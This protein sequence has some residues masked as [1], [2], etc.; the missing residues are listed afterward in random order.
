[1]G[2][3]NLPLRIKIFDTTLRDGEQTPGVNLNVNEKV[4]IA[5]QL[6]RLGVDVIEAGFAISSLGDFE[7]ITAVSKIIRDAK[8]ASLARTLEKDIDRAWESIKDAKMPRIHTFIA[9]SDIHMK[10]KLKMTEEE[11]LD[12]VI[13][14]VKYARNYCDDVEFSA[15]D[16]SRTRPEFLYRVVEEAIKAGAT[17]INI[18]DTVG[19]AMPQ[20]FGEL[21]RKIKCNVPNID[22]VDISVHCHDDLGL[23]VANS[24]F[25]IENGVVQVECTINGL[26]ERA[27][28]ASLEEVVMAIDT[29]KDY[30]KVEHKIDTTQIYRSSKLVSTLT[31]I[32]VQPNK[33]IVGANAFAHESGIHQHGVLTEK[34]T[35]EIM[36]PESIGLSQNRMVLGK[37]SG[38][39]AFEEKLK[40]MGYNL[41]EEQIKNAFQK[42][43]DLADRKK[44]ISDKDIEALVQEKVAKI[45]EVFQ[46]ETY[47]ISS[48]DK[49]VSTATISVKRN[50]NVYTEAATGS[51]PIDAAFKAMERAV[52]FALNL[53]DYSLK[54]VTGGKDALGEVIVRVSKNGNAFVG[55][56]VSTDIIEASVR[57]YLNA[58]NKALSELGEEIIE[59]IEQ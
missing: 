52:G 20:E 25:A 17:V 34:T 5:R 13:S 8:V 30:F 31:G 1:M 28:N 46:L 9:T 14:M 47:Q 41:N 35:Y 59:R 11:V 49:V 29:R 27:G 36:K 4:E 18:P 54:A 15:E 53:E 21:I 32:N 10:Y 2:V 26:G 48:G 38:R 56:G 43:K 44:D 51:G 12:R 19:Y 37:L 42:F 50:G 40:E 6:E 39:H 24:L 55:R 45:P 3:I 33:S 58:I 23:A 22:K 57:A 16:A 7:A